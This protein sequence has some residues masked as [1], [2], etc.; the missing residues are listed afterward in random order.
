[1]VAAPSQETRTIGRADRSRPLPLSSGQQQMWLLHQLAPTS[2]AYLMTWTLR[3]SGH[4]DVGALGRSWG[5]IVERHEILRTRYLQDDGGEP[6]QVVDTPAPFA[7]RVLDLAEEPAGRREV[8]AEQIADWERR[9]PFDLTR[10]QP[11]RVTVIAIGPE[12]HLMVVNIHHIAADDVSYRIITA[13]LGALYAEETSGVPAGLKE[14]E[15]QYAD[16]AVWE[17]ARTTDA[18][19]RPHLDYWRGALGGAPDLPLPL[20]RPRPARPDRR[21]GVV[22]LTVKPGTAEGVFAL[23][24]AQRATPFMVL[25]AAYH[26]MLSRL[27]GSDD[28]TV[29]LPVSTRLPHLDGLLGYA[30]NTVAVR[31]RQA[32]G[33]S[34][35]DVIAQVRAGFLDAFDHRF[36]PFKR[37]V[38]EVNPARALDGN[39]LFQAAFDMEGAEEGGGFRL[40]GLLTERV[41]STVAPDA[42]FDLTMHVAQSSDRRLFARLEYAAAVI[43]ERSVRAWAADWESLLDTLVRHPQEPI[44]A[45]PARPAAGAPGAQEQAQPAPGGARS[46]AALTER[47][48]R[49]WAEVLE[50]DSV[51]HQD[52]FFDVGG[53]SLRAVAL[54]ARLRTEGLE[55][56]ATDIFAYQSIE[57]LADWCAEQATG[58]PGAGAVPDPVAPFALIGAQ[59]REALPP[60]VADAY[61]LT[62]TQL[63]MIIELRARP[64]VNTYQDTTSYLVRDDR[65][66]DPAALQRATQLV[67]DRHEV[68]RTSFELNRYSVPLQL[69][70]RTARID[71]GVSDH[72]SLGTGGW[73]PALEEYAAQE[74]RSPMDI[75]G[76]PLIRVHAHRADGEQDWWITITECHPI[77]EGF[78][79]H[80]MLMEILTGYREIRAGG[81]PAE[82]APVPFRYADY[83]ASEAAARESQEDRDFWRGVVEGRTD[84]A[85]PAAWQGDRTLARER[86]QHMLD[87]RDL[88]EDLRRLATATGTSMKAVLLAAHMKVMSTVVA[89][90]DFYTGLVCDARPEIVGADQVLGMYLNTLPFAMPAGTRTWG[91]LVRAVY[92]GLT[93]LW[94]HRVFPMQVIQQEFGPGGRLLDVFFNYLDFRQVDK[95]LLDWDA[96]YNDN[97]NEFALHVFTISGILKLNT[98][99]HRLSREAAVRLT[100]L[101][102]TVLEQ[103]SLGPDGDARAACLPRAEREGLRALDRTGEQPHRP[104]PVAEALARALRE[105]PRDAAVRCGEESLSYEQLDVRADWIARGLRERGI[106][107]GDLVA[108]APGRYPG[109]VAAVLGVW[110][111]GAAF[112]P[113]ADG[114]DAGSLALVTPPADLPAGT[115]CVLA[116]DPGNPAAPGT[117]L[118]HRALEH[119]TGQ[120]LGELAAR[121]AGGARGSSWLCADPPTTAAGLLVWTAA[122]ASGGAVLLTT[123]PPAEAVPEMKALVSAGQVTHLRTTPLV[124]QRVLE[125]SPGPLTL[126]VDGDDHP[127][128]AVLA[129]LRGRATV[130]ET[131]GAD[132]L[133]GPVAFDGTPPPG[134]SLR[135]VDARLRRLPA[136]VV[137]ELRVGG[138]GDGGSG[139]GGDVLHRAGRLARIGRDGRLEPMGPVGPH[140]TAEL[141]GLHPS[142]LDCRVVRRADPANARQRLVG[143]LRVAAGEAFAPDDIRRAL[144]ERRL[145]R[146]LIPDVLVEVDD[147]PLTEAGTVD[148]ERLPEPPDSARPGEEPQA[149]PWDDGFEALL[150]DALAG[151]SFEGDL[152]PDVPLADAGLSSMATVGLIVAIEQ[153]YEIVIPDDF[154]VVDMFRTPRL[155]WEQICEFRA[156]DL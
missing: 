74:R 150:R 96:T 43:D 9:R 20:D 128:P 125:S 81:T 16:F 78:S 19:L 82:P 6:R 3:L 61:P 109:A 94:P 132:G 147:W 60:G 15:V 115:A 98:T 93:A 8:R 36:V 79:F 97:D 129:G 146:H 99:S 42:K 18:A 133:F 49:I 156:A 123:A 11:V 48:H 118:S 140:R 56:S 63:G 64:D 119:A 80:T 1:M 31:S 68:L 120:L 32:P 76:A 46:S 26:V 137:G 30:V 69:V 85:L 24:A 143:Y 58:A 91:D 59:D 130:I 134:L 22:E 144:A 4:L 54:A 73:R 139:D 103:M 50:L 100:A 116:A 135:V 75:T 41:G 113:A 110:R 117:A 65:E 35:A 114:P 28:V 106:G 107:P 53:D 47:M 72:G 121:G 40:A 17:R 27:T 14:P 154:Q 23:S 155:L 90:E 29:G 55:V 62:A 111:V 122:L 142:V 148:L 151:A 44:A 57:E 70:H 124:A 92:D 89:T 13:E 5:R 12:L 108:V 2:Q 141:L 126:V 138:T 149:K 67:V 51:G 86:Y 105:Y 66:L 33:Q 77:L 7:L 34:F 131:L 71:V 21:A 25:L 145:P 38:D 83:V 45:G 136:G 37:V 152:D 95:S 88:E 153:L 39:P 10:H 52:N 102:R 127:A 84:T 101:Y 87:F 112:T 104:L